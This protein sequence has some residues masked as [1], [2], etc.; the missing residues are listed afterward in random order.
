M[1][2][3]SCQLKVKLHLRLRESQE[4]LCEHVRDRVV[5]SALAFVMAAPLCQWKSDLNC[6]FYLCYALVKDAPS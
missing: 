3:P 1:Q 6:L 2:I 4:R 5:T